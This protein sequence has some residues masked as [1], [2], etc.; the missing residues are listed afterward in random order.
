LPITARSSGQLVL[1]T[2]SFTS[3]EGDAQWRL[4]A[5]GLIEKSTDNGRTWQQQASGVTVDLLA[6]SAATN[7]VAWIVG[8]AGVI[9]RT[10][11]GRQW[12]R[13]APPAGIT[14]DW[15]T[16][17]VRSATSATVVGSIRRFATEDGGMTWTEQ[18]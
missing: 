13:I 18:Q 11:D 9:L 5:A 16:V 4:G 14:D 8:R 3:P 2:Y 6:G 12:Q 17:V 7:E 1:Y 15:V 10:T